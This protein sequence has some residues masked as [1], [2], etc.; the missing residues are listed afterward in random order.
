MAVI[1][2]KVDKP[3]F[4]TLYCVKSLFSEII[5]RGKSDPFP[6]E[7]SPAWS[8]EGDF[9]YLILDYKETCQVGGG[10]SSTGRGSCGCWGA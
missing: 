4:P 5:T 3:I 6:K 7:K 1:S 2:K 9:A 8:Q 10:V